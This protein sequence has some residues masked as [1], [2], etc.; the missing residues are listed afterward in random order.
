M[1]TGSIQ[2]KKTFY[3]ISDEF[4]EYLTHYKRSAELPVHYENLL[5]SVDSY[6]LMNAKNEDTLWQTMVY[7]QHYGR[8]IFEGLKTIYVLPEIWRGCKYSSQ[9]LCRPGGLLHFW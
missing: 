3:P 9:S 8:E 2:Q 6:P 1:K 7:D 5:Q 4:R